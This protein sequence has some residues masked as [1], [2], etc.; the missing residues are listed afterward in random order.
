LNGRGA[1]KKIFGCAN[2]TVISGST[3]CLWKPNFHGFG[4]INASFT[5][6]SGNYSASNSSYL[7][8]Y[9]GTRTVTRGS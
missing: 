3:S 5:P 1:P 6:S 8:L 4:I 2:L 9:V 7:N